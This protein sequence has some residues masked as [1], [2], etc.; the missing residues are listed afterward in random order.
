MRSTIRGFASGLGILALVASASAFAQGLPRQIAWTAYD[1]GSTGYGQAIAIGAALKNERGVTLRVLPGKNDI[2]RLAPLA[3]GKVDFSAFGIG[4]YQASEGVFVFGRKD[5]GPQ[6]LRLLAMSNGDFCNSMIVAKDVGVETY[7][8]LKDKRVAYVVAA[9]ALN[10]NV[11]AFLRFGG[12]EWDDVRQVTFGGYAASMTGIVEGQVDA[13]NTN[14]TAGVAMQVM[15]SPRGGMYPPTPHDDKEGWA[16]MKEVA[17]YFFPSMCSEGAGIEEP[18]EAANYPYPILVAYEEK[19]T[20][21]VYEMTKAMFELHPVYEDSA[22]GAN[23]WALEK[24]VLDWVLPYHEGAIRYL[25]EAGVWSGDL[26]A[27]N[28]ALVER[29]DLLQK[30]W[31]AYIEEAP[32]DEAAFDQGWQKARLAALEEAG[33]SPVFTTW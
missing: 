9:P 30:A 11:Y 32:D 27:H 17:P 26:Q 6:R 14:T 28:D 13:A 10:H 33:Q 15:S 22:P 1:V 24:Q 5:W 21:V 12:L 18:F 2:S 25:E 8:D 29:Q 20:D 3:A 23:G 19:E 16:R 4:G 31:E 7:A